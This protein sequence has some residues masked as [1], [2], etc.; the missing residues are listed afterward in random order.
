MSVESAGLQNSTVHS[1]QCG[2][3][4]S[5]FSSLRLAQAFLSE[6]VTGGHLSGKCFGSL[7]LKGAPFPDL[8]CQWCIC[9]LSFLIAC[10]SSFSADLIIGHS[11][12]VFFE[13]GA[14]LCYPSAQ[15]RWFLV[16]LCFGGGSAGK[17]ISIQ[18][19]LGFSISNACVVCIFSYLCICGERRTLHWF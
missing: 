8:S 3:G 15:H 7:K 11:L 12:D 19:P 14:L 4:A 2:T 18:V 10:P 17:I 13:A 16:S 6:Q 9:A 1:D 5:V